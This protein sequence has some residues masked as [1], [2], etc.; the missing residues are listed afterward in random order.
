M[1]VL[2]ALAAGLPVLG[3]SVV[4][5]LIEGAGQ[6]VADEDTKVYAS[7][8]RDLAEPERRRELATA[9]LERARAF[10]WESA[11]AAFIEVLDVV[12]TKRRRRTVMARGDLP[13]PP[14]EE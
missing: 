8:L 10:S 3:S 4:Q 11:A 12:D 2:E 13:F 6:V 5:W 14:D 9:A 7:A 1:V